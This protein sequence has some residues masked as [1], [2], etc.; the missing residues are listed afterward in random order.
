M[1]MPKT[2][3]VFL[4]NSQ[5]MSPTDEVLDRGGLDNT[6]RNTRTSETRRSQF[7]HNSPPDGGW[8][9]VV[10]FS[11][12]FIG[13]IL[14]GISYSF[15]LFFKELYTYFNESRSLTSWIISTLNGTYLS[16]GE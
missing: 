11:A 9:W 15:G 14:D 16:I 3:P 2:K 1:D 5:E 8:G 12:F 10:T 4:C 13:L 7:T 6:T